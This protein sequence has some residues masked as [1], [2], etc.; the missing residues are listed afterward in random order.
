VGRAG[1]RR[2]AEVPLLYATQDAAARGRIGETVAGVLAA[3]GA[4]GP[5]AAHPVALGGALAALRAVGLDFEARSLALE[6]ALAE[7]V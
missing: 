1:Q 4:A 5:A 3:L 7:G 2:V 6:A